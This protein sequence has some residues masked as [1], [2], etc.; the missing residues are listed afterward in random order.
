MPVMTLLPKLMLRELL[1]SYKQ[2]AVIA[3]KFYPTEKTK[4]FTPSTN[5]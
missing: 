3:W 5:P 2:L 1:S 4:V